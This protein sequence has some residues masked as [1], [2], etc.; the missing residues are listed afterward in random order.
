MRAPD[1]LARFMDTLP[2]ATY[3][4]KSAVLATSQLA[5]L[6]IASIAIAPQSQPRPDTRNS[7]ARRPLRQPR[8]RTTLEGSVPCTES[9]P[10]R[11]PG[12]RKED[13]GS[14]VLKNA[15]SCQPASRYA[16]RC[17][18]CPARCSA[19][20]KEERNGPFQ[21]LSFC[22]QPAS[23]PLRRTHRPVYSRRTR[24]GTVSAGLPRNRTWLSQWIPTS[25]TSYKSYFSNVYSQKFCIHS[26]SD[27]YLPTLTIM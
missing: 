2:T 3:K 18:R 27:L 21:G 14:A 24:L 8:Q 11:K 20:R 25:H 12:G 5:P 6:E 13:R 10:Q 17:A 22:R 19:E 9:L 16:E 26:L 4:W 23:Q 15:E 7:S 1:M